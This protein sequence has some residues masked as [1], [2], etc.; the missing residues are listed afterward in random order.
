MKTNINKFI[1][2]KGLFESLFEEFE[3]ELKQDAF[4]VD[5]FREILNFKNIGYSQ[6]EINN[7][8]C[9]ID[10]TDIVFVFESLTGLPNES[11]PG[12]DWNIVTIVFNR[13]LDEFT[14]FE[15]E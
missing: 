7:G 5:H 1:D 11:N 14:S 13:I 10:E 6:Y 15:I 4:E 12:G 9:Q 8:E 3:E 2:F